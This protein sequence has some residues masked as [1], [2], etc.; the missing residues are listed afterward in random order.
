MPLSAAKLPLKFAIFHALE[1][2]R[3]TIP[4]EAEAG[5]LPTAINKQLA[6]KLA[7]AIHR[8]ATQATVTTMVVTAVVG[9]AAPLAPAGATRAAGAGIGMGH[10]GV[11]PGTGLS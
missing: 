9:V 1:E 11:V 6:T 2:A 8:Y 5:A 7:E 3:N 10:G 4:K